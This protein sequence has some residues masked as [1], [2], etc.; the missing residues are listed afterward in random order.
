ME[1]KKFIRRKPT[2]SKK[3]TD[4]TFPW[5]HL[6]GISSVLFALIIWTIISEFRVVEPLYLPSP[7]DLYIRFQEIKDSLADNYLKTFF[8]MMVGFVIGSSAGILVSLVMGRSRIAS[9]LT[10][11]IIQI[12]KPIPALALAPF[13]MLWWGIGVEGAFFLVIYGCFFVMVIDG[14]QA[15]KNVP[16]I[17]HWAGAALG[18]TKSRIYS[19]IVLP[20]IIPS[21]VGGLRVCVVMAFNLV[22]LAEFNMA[23]GGL[24]DIIIKG[25]RFLRTDILILGILFVVALAVVTD[26][27]MVII[28][29]KVIRWVG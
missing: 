3:K 27:I 7:S 28:S 15:I 18:A 21:I 10:N 14:I 19:K 26:L 12:L 17:Y 16:K 2:G 9:A 1:E 6:L 22:I 20:Y 23:S 4:A 5:F 8:R 11:P 13:A 29:R 24:G 25:Y